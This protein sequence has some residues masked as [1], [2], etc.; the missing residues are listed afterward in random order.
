MLAQP[1]TNKLLLTTTQ[2]TNEKWVHRRRQVIHKTTH[3]TDKSGSLVFWG[4]KFFKVGVISSERLE[5]VRNCPSGDE[6][7]PTSRDELWELSDSAAL[8]PLAR[9]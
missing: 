2:T 3:N 1:L 6:A 4:F 9:R 7:W 5:Q 8:V